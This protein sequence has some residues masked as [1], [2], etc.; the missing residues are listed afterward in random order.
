MNKCYE[1][2]KQS[3]FKLCCPH[4]IIITSCLNK[5]SSKHHALHKIA[6]LPVF[7]VNVVCKMN[8]RCYLLLCVSLCIY[9]KILWLYLLLIVFALH[10]IKIH[11]SLCN[12]CVKD[13]N[14]LRFASFS[15]KQVKLLCIWLSW[16][17]AAEGNWIAHWKL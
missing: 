15:I 13:W 10:L 5:E 3:H 1:W 4:P 8:A 16:L 9:L 2:F 12:R 17:G 7:I 11:V 6:S 14:I